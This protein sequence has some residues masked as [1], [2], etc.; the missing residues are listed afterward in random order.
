MAFRIS[1]LLIAIFWTLDAADDGEWLHVKEGTLKTIRVYI[2]QLVLV[3]SAGAG[4]ATF[5]WQGPNIG[6]NTFTPRRKP[7][8]K[9]TTPAKP[10]TDVSIDVSA[11]A[12]ELP[13]PQIVVQG[14]SNLY[15]AHFTMLPFTV[16][17][18]PLLLLQKPMGQAVLALT[19]I[20]ILS[21]L[22]LL[23]LL[24]KTYS[25]TKADP[26]L[27]LGATILALL[28][29]FCYFK[30]GHQA[31]LSSIQWTAAYIPLHTLRY[32]WSPILIVL[33][34][35]AGQILCAAAVPCLVFWRRPYKFSGKS[36]ASTI[37]HSTIFAPPSA[38]TAVSQG[39]AKLSGDI[40]GRNA[41]PPEPDRRDAERRVILSELAK[42]HLMHMIVY[43]TINLAT[44]VFAGHLRRHLMLYRVFCPRWMLG[45]AGLVIVELVSCLIGV[46]G[47]RWTMQALTRLFGW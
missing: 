10:Q 47:A 11:A 39:S 5:A 40:T 41:A 4:T 15:G 24:R 36:S 33:N 14:T 9:P 19:T 29:Q 6:I 37:D 8:P 7:L 35:F 12:M 3:I 22:E 34:T 45:G 23:H 25:T 32:P 27:S 1:L 26:S 30:T 16:I 46:G 21:L 38:R 2:A 17:L 43:S 28:G 20:S 13:R 42:A 44:T 31:A 18:T